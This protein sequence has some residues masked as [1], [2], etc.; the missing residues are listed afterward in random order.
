MLGI[1]QMENLLQQLFMYEDCTKENR[2]HSQQVLCNEILK[3]YTKAVT[4]LKD[5]NEELRRNNVH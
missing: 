5:A 2:I 1:G 4:A 3:Y